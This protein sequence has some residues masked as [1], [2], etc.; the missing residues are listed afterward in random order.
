MEQRLDDIYRRNLK[1]S[2]KTLSQC[3]FFHHKSHMD[4]PGRE[5]A[6]LQQEDGD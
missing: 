6:P 1:N 4:C 5:P 3:H 2:E